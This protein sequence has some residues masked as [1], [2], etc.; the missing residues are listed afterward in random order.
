[1]PHLGLPAKPV[2]VMMVLLS[3]SL[4]DQNLDPLADQFPALVP[5]EILGLRIDLNDDAFLIYRNDRVRDGF[6]QAGRE[7]R[8]SDTSGQI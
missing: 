1:L 8:L 4:R 5:E 7:K 3:L 6:E 2:A